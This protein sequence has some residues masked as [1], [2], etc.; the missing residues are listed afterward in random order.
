[1]QVQGSGRV[2]NAGRIEIRIGQGGRTRARGDNGVG[3]LQTLFFAIC[4]LNDQCR[5]VL[6][7]WAALHKGHFA[8]LTQLSQAVGQAFDHPFFPTP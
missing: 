2:Q 5:G 8:A 3:K 6:K 1:M 4:I 7:A